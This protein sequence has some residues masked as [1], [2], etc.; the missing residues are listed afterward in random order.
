MSV[1]RGK[2]KYI[3]V[4]YAHKDSEKVLPVIENMQREGF[5][6]WYDTGIEAGTEWPAYIQESLEESE[7]VLAFISSNSI[8]SFYCRSEI[9]F[10]LS[11]QKNILVVYLENAELKYGLGL[12]LASLQSLFRFRHS[13]EGSFLEE[14]MKAKILRECRKD[15]V[16]WDRI[17]RS[18]VSNE[19][20]VTGPKT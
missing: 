5:R 18:G 16:S 3:F 9:T 13:S 19:K 10:A 4:S 2:E 6:V 1:Y 14:L 11:N 7:V 12:Q 8:E 20:E 17:F 15:G